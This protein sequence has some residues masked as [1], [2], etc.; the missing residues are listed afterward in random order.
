[1]TDQL[2]PSA[3]EHSGSQRSEQEPSNSGAAPEQ[4][5]ASFSAPQ[6]PNSERPPSSGDD[7]TEEQAADAG[8]ERPRRRRRG[9][10]GRRRGAAGAASESAAP[11]SAGTGAEDAAE[12]ESASSAEPRTSQGDESSSAD[13]P[14][15]SWASGSDAGDSTRAPGEV[16]LDATSD[17][18]STDAGADSAGARRSRRRRGG[19][20]RGRRGAGGAGEPTVADADAHGE[21]DAAREPTDAD[22]ADH[23]AD[24]PAP[25]LDAP[26]FDDD[27]DIPA[28]AAAGPS[29]APGA[30]QPRNG[31][32]SRSGRRRGRRRGRRGGGASE[33]GAAVESAAKPSERPAATKPSRE[34]AKAGSAEPSG[35]KRSRRSRRRRGGAA[36]QGPVGVEWI[37]G[38]ENELELEAPETEREDESSA[39]ARDG[40]GEPKAE[41]GRR[42]GKRKERP[43]AQEDFDV[44]AGARPKPGRPNIILVN[45][46]DRE[47]IRVAVVEGGQIVD[48]QMH[49]KRHETL[50]NDIYRGKVVNLEPAIGA[51]FI[52]FGEGRNGFLHTSDVLA[53]Y[54]D[55]DWRLDKLLTHKIDP[56]EWD[57]KSSQPHVA[58]ELG[59]AQRDAG[60]RGAANGAR[61][62]QE[63]ADDSDHDA[64]EDDDADDEVVASGVESAGDEPHDGLDHDELHERLL[65]HHD[66]RGHDELHDHDHD[67]HDHLA[68][69][70]DH[71]H[72]PEVLDASEGL[73]LLEVI[74]EHDAPPADG[75]ASNSASTSDESEDVE[76]VASLRARTPLARS[77]SD[78]LGWAEPDAAPAAPVSTAPQAPEVE[79]TEAE[80]RAPQ[81]AS[82]GGDRAQRGD[83]ARSAEGGRSGRGGRGG[84]GS[85]EAEARRHGRPRARPRL[86]ITDLLEKGQSVVVQVTKDAIGDKGPTLTTYISI[87]GRYLVL[88]PSMSRTGVSRKIEDEKERRRLKRILES[89]DVPEGMGV[90]VRTAGTGCTREDLRRDLDYLMLLWDTFG[91]RLNL[92]R[93]PAP[94]YEESDVAIRT[95]RDLFNDH[96][97]AVYVDDEKVYQRVREFMEKLIPEKVDRVQL[98]TGPKPLFH[99]HNVEQDFERIF[100][101]RI[102][103]ASGG[104]IVL[105]Q[106]EA[107]VAIDVNSG[108]TRSEGFDFENIALRT[109]LDAVKEIARQ[110]RLRDLGG[111]IVCDFIDMQRSSSR[112]QVERALRDAMDSDRARSKL[113]RISQFGLLELTRQRL[114]PGLS[115]MLFSNC[116]RCRGSGRI[117][118]VESRVGAI[119][120]RLGAALTLK[121]FQKVELRAAPEVVE[122]LRRYCSGELRELEARHERQIELFAAVDQ[123]EDSV[124]RYLR[125]DGREVRPGGRRKR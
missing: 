19:R 7:A 35:S 11:E 47:E 32:E 113:G 120:R 79:A 31:E 106:T 50:V 81:R 72:A 108:K 41:A 16:E 55:P 54:G 29:N 33:N 119:L 9:G 62:P 75:D 68:P 77:S 107:L 56:E 59:Q 36:A 116:P 118:T 5:A 24:A 46:A 71:A 85:R 67:S 76:H 74:E 101:R 87:P 30:A 39:P 95:I 111:I 42:R 78:E 103:L 105:D 83:G 92:G 73:E 65:A 21:A 51:A 66:E 112:R 117:R 100:A 110:I 114:G 124:L 13:A 125:A 69:F 58:A 1:M 27:F 90:I 49:V 70:E 88:M 3:F 43:E 57:E 15:E 80:E 82:A 2:P 14:G 12:D 99:T 60:S 26:A 23:A 97:E 84:R 8:Q 104:S 40:R 96:T 91:K 98:H 94:L 52:D 20:R 48:F 63:L 17:S 25:D 22:G 61:K 89:L 34:P 115:K 28:A 123:L 109:N 6:V 10:R 53:V 44:D 38:E 37:P 102:D 86:P 93:G 121:G 4:V 45:A 18:S 122:H 64:D